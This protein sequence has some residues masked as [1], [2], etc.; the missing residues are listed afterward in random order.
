MTTSVDNALS[1]DVD[2]FF[3]QRPDSP[4]PPLLRSEDTDFL[5][6]DMYV[7]NVVAGQQ[8]PLADTASPLQRPSPS[9]R[10]DRSVALI[11]A[12]LACCTP[13]ASVCRS[14]GTSLSLPWHLFVAPMALNLESLSWHR[15]VDGAGLSRLPSS[16]SPSKLRPPRSRPSSCRRRPGPRTP[17]ATPRHRR[18]Q[19]QPPAEHTATSPAWRISISSVACRNCAVR[20]AVQELSGQ[21]LSPG[22]GALPGA[23]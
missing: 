1:T 7:V 22:P 3:F 13:M 14:D 16:S 15:R 20:C 11:R 6:T 19:V 4:A 8:S 12:G 21:R 17:P 9:V 2:F 18:L 10:L 23:E 5:G